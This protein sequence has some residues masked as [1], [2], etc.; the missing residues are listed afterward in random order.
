MPHVI[1]VRAHASAAAIHAALAGARAHDVALAFPLGV[2]CLA[3]TAETMRGLHAQCLALQK[4]AVI[5]GGDEHLRAVA[6]AAG[7]PVATS[8]AEWE[9]TLPSLAVVAPSLGNA[10]AS[11]DQPYLSLVPFA[12]ERDRDHDP[13]D[14]FDDMP[15]N[16]V[17]ELMARDGVYGAPDETDIYNVRHE[18]EPSAEDELL[19]AHERY[20]EHIT[21]AIRHTGGL[22]LTHTIRTTHPPIVPVSAGSPE[23]PEGDGGGQ[24]SL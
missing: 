13:F 2:P 21:R 10:S 16:F 15:P 11:W 9:A 24:P 7:F 6:V 20:E 5:L 14:P 8:L 17:L 19:A 18:A 4:D 23:P 22:A 1:R 3:G 12:D